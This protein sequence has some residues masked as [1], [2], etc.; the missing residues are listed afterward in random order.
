MREIQA[1]RTL[2]K[3]RGQCWVTSQKL[4]SLAPFEIWSCTEIFVKMGSAHF[5]WPLCI[6]LDKL[7]QEAAGSLLGTAPLVVG[8]RTVWSEQ[9]LITSCAW[10][11]QLTAQRER[12]SHSEIRCDYNALQRSCVFPF[13]K[14]ELGTDLFV[15][16]AAQ[17]ELSRASGHQMPPASIR[18]PCYKSRS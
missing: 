2:S 11:E 14:L 4:F 18:K 17:P 15:R 1:F 13:R 8:V 16:P 5:Q 6:R 9:R 10:E 12:H 7:A 3:D